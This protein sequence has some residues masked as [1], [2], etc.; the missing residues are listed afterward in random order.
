[1]L[2]MAGWMNDI[3]RSVEQIVD[4]GKCVIMLF[5]SVFVSICAV[6]HLSLAY[7]RM[8]MYLGAQQDGHRRM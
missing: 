2:N 5:W 1:M 8:Y 7:C 4:G 6:S 3:K